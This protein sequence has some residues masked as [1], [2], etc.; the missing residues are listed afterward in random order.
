MTT[1]CMSNLRQLG[2]AASIYMNE[3]NGYLPPWGTQDGNGV[4]NAAPEPYARTE[5]AQTWPA[6]LAQ[7]L[8]LTWVWD[9]P[10]LK[11]V[12]VFQCPASLSMLDM[13]SAGTTIDNQ[14]CLAERPI[15]YSI[16]WFT[17]TSFPAHTSWLNFTWSK[18]TK[19][20]GSE[21]ILFADSSSVRVDGQVAAS[22]SLWPWYFSH[23]ASQYEVAFRHG[24]V[25]QELCGAWNFIP[26]PTGLANAAFLDGHV[27]SLDW[28]T[29][30]PQNLS[31][32]NGARCGNTGVVGP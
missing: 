22:Q 29:F 27:D 28:K 14:S 5:E 16:T 17:S 13:V 12:P 21:F 20:S 26:K 1:Q 11:T 4:W 30:S 25:T 10:Q 2:M 15:T 31:A 19:W 7:E 18:G 6:V 9:D 32:S 8:G 23:W 24:N 3:Y